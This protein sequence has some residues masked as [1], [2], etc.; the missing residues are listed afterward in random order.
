[1]MLWAPPRRR[2]APMI[3][4]PPDLSD[5]GEEAVRGVLFARARA[6]DPEAVRLIEARYRLRLIVLSPAATEPAPPNRT[7]GR[8]CP[9]GCH[10]TVTGK[11]KKHCSHR[12]RQRTYRRKRRAE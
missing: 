8:E 7:D 1:M 4:N 2:P 9:G 11:R 6:G 10:N 3:A 12:C 5:P